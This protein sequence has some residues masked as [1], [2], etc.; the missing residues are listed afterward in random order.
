MQI[1]KDFRTNSLSRPNGTETEHRQDLREQFLS[2]PKDDS[3][4][5]FH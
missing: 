2:A 5:Q 4:G 3:F 1:N